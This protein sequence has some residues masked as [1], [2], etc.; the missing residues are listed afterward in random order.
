MLRQNIDMRRCGEDKMMAALDLICT[1]AFQAEC[2]WTGASRKGPKTAIM[3]HQRFVDVC[4]EIGSS[5]TELINPDKVAAFFMKKLKNATKRKFTTGQRR[6]TRHCSVRRRRPSMG[7]AAEIEKPNNTMLEKKKKK[8]IL[9]LE[10]TSVE[11]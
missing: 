2:T 10:V 3:S 7:A 8:E 5:P 6:R 11:Q 9:V 1:K 4:M